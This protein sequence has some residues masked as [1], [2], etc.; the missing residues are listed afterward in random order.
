MFYRYCDT[1]E[2]RELSLAIKYM[3]EHSDM[4][5]AKAAQQHEAMNKSPYKSSWLIQ[6]RA[7]IWRCFLTQIRDFN[8]S[9]IRILQS[10]LVA[11][12]M[13]LVYFN[14]QLNERG[15]TNINGAFSLFTTNLSFANC[16]MVIASFPR[17]LPIFFREHN[18]GMY[19]V[20]T[21]FIAKNIAEFLTFI[22][23]PTVFV[24]ANYWMIG[25]RPG[26]DAV[27]ICW[28]AAFLVCNAAV[29]FG[30]L[31]STSLARVDLCLTIST[32]VLLVAMYL[33]GFNLNLSTLPPWLSW[34]QYLS[35]FRYG[36]EIFLVNQWHNYD[37]LTCSSSMNM[38]TFGAP[39]FQK[40]DDILTFVGFQN[41][42]YILD[43]SALVGIIL[44]LRFSAYL[45]LWARAKH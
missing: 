23:V 10:V 6:M 36:Y 1:E 41:S 28:I 44:V 18:N 21:Y 38:S 3:D 17:E 2:Y 25:L 19:R 7:L 32:P 29:S 40:G 37:E 27:L 11:G 33:N 22:I 5:L 12:L 16:I 35:W 30:Y 39:C 4:E 31:L 14:Q 13:A 26:W 9:I 42:N 43:F 15:V 24:F 8:V 34:L 45:A 20:D